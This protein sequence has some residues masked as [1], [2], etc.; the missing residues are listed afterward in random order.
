[1]CVVKVLLTQDCCIRIRKCTVHRNH[2]D[3]HIVTKV[4]LIKVRVY[5]MN[6]HILEK[7]PTFALFAVNPLYNLRICRYT[8]VFI[9]VINVNTKHFCGDFK[10]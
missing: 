2:M 6:E 1:M 8:C 4:S 5:L 9:Q 10:D 7:N 3:V